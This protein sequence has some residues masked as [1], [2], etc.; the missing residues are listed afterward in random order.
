MLEIESKT[1]KQRRIICCAHCEKKNEYSLT[2]TGCL[3][4]SDIFFVGWNTGTPIDMY[5]RR[6]S[7]PKVRCEHA[8]YSL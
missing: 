6:A 1:G 5:V 3:L 2:I 7:E 4:S 8:E